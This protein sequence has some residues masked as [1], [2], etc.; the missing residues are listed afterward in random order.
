VGDQRTHAMCDTYVKA[1]GHKGGV[2]DVTGKVG[3]CKAD[4]CK[5]NTAL[6]CSAQKI[7]VGMHKGHADCMTFSNK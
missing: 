3:A 2:M 6:E 4:G 1:A 7:S 5:F